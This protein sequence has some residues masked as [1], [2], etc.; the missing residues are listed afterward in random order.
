MSRTFNMLRPVD[1]IWSVYIDNY[2]KGK[3][4]KQFDLLY[5]NS[6]ST[7]MPKEVYLFYLRQFYQN[8][9][10]SRGKLKLNGVDIDL[11]NVKIPVFMQAGEKDHIAPFRSIYRSAK[12]FGGK[13]R[14]MLAGSGHIAGVVNH[15]DRMKYHYSTNDQLPD[16]VEQ[17]MEGAERH[18]YSW[19]PYWM[20]WLNEISPDRVPARQPGDGDLDVI[21][22]APGRYVK[23]RAV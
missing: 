21:E 1:L 10:L 3:E 20:E 14:F 13:T 19:W 6:D 7:G 9:T 8:N 5:W 11:R 2:L 12:L 22:D 23:V 16:T 18:A 17:W 15:P 4:P